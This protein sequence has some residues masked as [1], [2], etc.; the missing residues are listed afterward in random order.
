LNTIKY[1]IK[2]FSFDDFLQLMDYVLRKI[3]SPGKFTLVQ[4][5]L[6]AGV[7]L[8]TVITQ[9]IHI[10]FVSTQKLILPCHDLQDATLLKYLGN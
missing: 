2:K 1:L 7:I 8:A 5:I 4:I 3:I 9:E 6:V 10:P